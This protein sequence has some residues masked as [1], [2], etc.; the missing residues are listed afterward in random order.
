MKYFLLLNLFTVLFSCSHHRI[1][2][3]LGDGAVDL[4]N[5]ESLLR[6]SKNK[7]ISGEFASKP[8]ASCHLGNTF[9][10][11]NKLRTDFIRKQMDQNYW[12]HL[13][14]C[15]FLKEDWG[16]AEFY[17]QQALADARVPAIKA[18]ALNNLALLQF[19]FKLWD[20]AE[21]NLLEAISFLSKSK[22]P[23]FNLAQLYLHLGNYD[24]AL[25]I[26]HD[27]TLSNSA[28]S[29][30][31]YSLANAYLFKGDLVNAKKYFD[32]LP[33]SAFKRED[34]ALTYT[35]FFL[36]L[37]QIHVAKSYFDNRDISGI[38]EL[39]ALAQIVETKLNDRLIKE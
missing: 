34:I 27:K 25:L 8:I 15:Y 20:V 32:L 24:K 6:W 35:I 14:N 19:K 30:I 21:K 38:V 37:N 2:R 22:I 10:A 18:L 11:L 31:N 13:G 4:F 7:L 29:E 9:E 5:D 16:K 39:K 23:R 1:D 26:L 28:D 17:Y 36:Q 33:P 12:I 3:R